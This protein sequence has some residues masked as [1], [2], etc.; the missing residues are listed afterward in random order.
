MVSDSIDSASRH[1][2][3][4]EIPNTICTGKF[5]EHVGDAGGVM[6]LVVGI[7]IA[8]SLKRRVKFLSPFF[9]GGKTNVGKEYKTKLGVI[10]GDCIG[11]HIPCFQAKQFHVGTDLFAK[12]EGELDD[13]E[14]LR[15]YA[16]SVWVV[17]TLHDGC[18]DILE[19]S[20]INAFEIGAISGFKDGVGE[21]GA[22][23]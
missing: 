8:D 7:L 19:F 23:I 14:E 9:A 12:V 1:R 13:V 16:S 6:D 21:I 18:E 5:T 15:K 20:V 2:G 10:H 11:V 3:I 17:G 22:N 4:I